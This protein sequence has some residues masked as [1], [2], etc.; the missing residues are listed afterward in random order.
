MNNRI[1][2]DAGYVL[3]QDKKQSKGT[4][5]YD[6]S[7]DD[8]DNDS[9]MAT[10][11]RRVIRTK[12]TK[13]QRIKYI[14][15]DDLQYDHR[16]QSIVEPNNRKLKMRRTSNG[17][18]VVLDED[19]NVIKIIR[20]AR[21]PTPPPVIK[22]RSVKIR[23][24]QPQTLYYE[25]SDGQFVTQ[26]P[27]NHTI[28][29]PRTELIYRDDEPTKL[30]RKLII[31]P[32]TGDQ[33][34]IYENKPQKQHRKKY[35]VRKQI[36]ESPLDSDDE[37]GQQI[38]PQYVQ[39]VQRQPLPMQTIIKQEKPTSKYVMIRKKVDSEP[40]YGLSSSSSI[41]TLKNNQRIV[42]ETPTKKPSATYVYS[43]SGK[44]YK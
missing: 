4:Q 31:D 28:I 17:D 11:T 29:K 16:R 43:T 18:P 32:R 24:R 36:N 25:T 41:P 3:V 1:N 42:Y 13:E 2:R 14:S 8:D 10:V 22:N 9:Q 44:Y 38:Q 6:D 7:D 26:P 5:Y 40:V 19:D 39:V 35:I 15:T 30:L 33:E 20:N 27:K 12:P 34:T 21:S 37:D 23:P